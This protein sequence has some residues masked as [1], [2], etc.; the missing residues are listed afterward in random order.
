M[1]LFVSLWVYFWA[2]VCLLYAAYLFFGNENAAEV[3]FEN[4]PPTGRGLRRVET[5]LG[6]LGCFMCLFSFFGLY[7]MK[8]EYQNVKALIRIYSFLAFIGAAVS[9][10]EAEHSDYYGIVRASPITFG[11]FQLVV[12]LIGL[13]LSQSASNPFSDS[14]SSPLIVQVFFGA[15]AA[16]LSLG[17]I[18]P[19]IVLPD[20]SIE[21]LYNDFSNS[22]ERAQVCLLFFVFN[23]YLFVSSLMALYGFYSPSRTLIIQF[24]VQ[25]AAVLG[26]ISYLLGNKDDLGVQSQFVSGYLVLNALFFLFALYS[27]SKMPA[28]LPYNEVSP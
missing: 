20:K 26:F 15:V 27:H 19:A 8:R 12:L 3:A 7:V 23:C 22:Q 9:F 16:C 25:F 10:Y 4:S 21:L 17:S 28:T 18:F 11:Y 6:A 1:S 2:F 13:Y 14:R 5:L 24:A